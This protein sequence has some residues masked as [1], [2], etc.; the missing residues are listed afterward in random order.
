M[1]LKNTALKSLNLLHRAASHLPA[2]GSFRPLRGRFSAFDLVERGRLE[3]EV[4][5]AQQPVGSC[6]PGSMTERA[7]FRQHDHQPWPV[8]WARSKDARLVGRMLLWRDR[9]ERVC[10]EAVYGID[11]RRRLGEDGLLAQFFVPAPELVAG[12]WTTLTSPWNDG[13]NYYH[14]LLDGLARLSLCRDF[15]EQPGI[16]LP[17]GLPR[18]ALETLSLLGLEGRTREVTSRCIQPETYYFCAPTAMTGVWNP[19]AFRWLRDRFSSYFM[20]PK[21]GSP[22]FLTRRGNARVP[23]NLDEIEAN[24]SARG[25]E[26][27]DCGA[28]PVKRQIEM[29]S[30]APAVAGLHG[31]A[32]T[33]LL[34][35]TP[36][37][38]VI[39]IFEAGYL[40]GCYEQ[41]AFHGDL[42]Y[43]LLINTGPGAIRL[44]DE[45]CLADTCLP[46]P[47]PS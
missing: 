38:P 14:W 35:A 17:P 19:D 30:A 34:W 31:A 4:V 39:E 33:N 20:P 26:I 21:S 47:E 41:I 15:P 25:F 1:S 16:L 12:A 37:T 45:W 23:T 28:I 42:N 36:A 22:V 2:C 40:N 10:S 46:I 6:P 9:G 32:M 18:F 3:G 8:F 27:V 5:A 7:G 44:L 43:R 11:G 24:F 13:R 29:V